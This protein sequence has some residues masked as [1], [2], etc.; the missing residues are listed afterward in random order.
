M[1]LSSWKLVNPK[2]RIV[3]AVSSLFVPSV[4]DRVVFIKKEIESLFK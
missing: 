3:V 2:D 1:R 4:K